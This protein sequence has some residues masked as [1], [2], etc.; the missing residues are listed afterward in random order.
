MRSLS[1]GIGEI[2]RGFARDNQGE[3]VEMA[4]YEYLRMPYKNWEIIVD[5]ESTPNDYKHVAHTR[6]RVLILNPQK[7]EF[8]IYPSNVFSRIGK[9]M[10]MQDVAIGD[11]EFDRYFIIKGNITRYVNQLFSD[12]ALRNTLVTLDRPRMYI[13]RNK[14][15]FRNRKWPKMVDQLYL[16][17][18][19]EVE[20]PE[21]LRDNI[22]LFRLTLDRMV[23]V[24]AISPE[25]PGA[26]F[27]NKL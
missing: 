24:G 9:G 10:G 3:F 14:G 1:K 6:F 5:T 22:Q 19:L 27:Y 20:N 25:N 4:T 16:R 18:S 11:Q 17:E 2:W 8:D 12:Q 26:S 15:L 23:E 13:E 7:F 21:V